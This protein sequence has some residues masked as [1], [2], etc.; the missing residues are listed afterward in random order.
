MREKQE[1]RN[2]HI[3][4]VVAT[5]HPIIGGAERQALEQGR[6]LR[7][8]GLEATIVTFRHNKSWAAHDTIDGVPVIR[9]A[10]MLLGRRDKLPRVLQ[11]FLYFVA[12]IV[13]GW[14]LW[15]HRHRYDILHVYQL[16]LLALPTACACYLGGKPMVV[17]VRC[18]D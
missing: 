10:G 3:F 4:I 18:A 14:V 9:I 16:N 13:M 1:N 6:S 7:Q 5:F 2:M 15:R 11:K 17:A 12:L 8:R